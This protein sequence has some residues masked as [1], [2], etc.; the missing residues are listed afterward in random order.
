MD[1][2][3]RAKLKSLAHDLDVII[4]IGKNGVTDET[5][6]VVASAFNT[7][8]LI[9]IKVIESCPENKNDVAV[10]LSQRTN[11]QVVQVI[12]SKIVLYKKSDKN[13][14]N[15]TQISNSKKYKA[16]SFSLNNRILSQK[17]SPNN[18]FKNGKLKKQRSFIAR[19]K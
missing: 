10:K 18:F 5:V 12:G 19:H 14:K 4:Q 15:K 16:E 13:K 3:Q 9:K 17:K 8:E 11:S 2:K 1:S 7:R 6:D